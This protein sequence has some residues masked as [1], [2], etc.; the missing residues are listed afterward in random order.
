MPPYP[1]KARDTSRAQSVEKASQS[2][3]H[4]Q[5]I[6]FKSFS[7]AACTWAKTLLRL[8]V[9]NLFAYGEQIMRAAD[10][11]NLSESPEGDFRQPEPGIHPGLSLFIQV[12]Y[13]RGTPARL[14]AVPGLIIPVVFVD[15]AKARNA[16]S[17]PCFLDKASQTLFKF[18]RTFSRRINIGNPDSLIPIR[19]G[20]VVF[21]YHGVSLNP[22]ENVFGKR[23]GRR[24]QREHGFPNAGMEQ[25]PVI[26]P[27]QPF[28]IWPGIRACRVPGRKT[29][30]PVEGIDML[31]GTV[32][33]A[34]AQCLFHGIVVG[35]AFLSRGFHG[36]H[37][38]DFTLGLKMGGKP[39]AP[40]FS[41]CSIECFHKSQINGRRQ[42]R[43]MQNSHFF[44]H[45]ISLH[46]FQRRP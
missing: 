34:E 18:F 20:I 33:P 38:P 16:L 6:K 32:N 22:A 23:I 28:D 9:W 46:T 41:V 40:L 17:L 35:K 26:Q 25:T 2:L 36:E 1:T 3:L 21:P 44:S 4:S 5:Q 42:F 39:P 45:W 30:R 7:T 27:Y 19:Q 12:P 31:D 11:K 37:K 43:Q 29:L 24:N 10:C 8:Q 15:T 13:H 14:F